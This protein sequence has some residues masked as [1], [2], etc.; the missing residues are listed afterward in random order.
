MSNSQL[1][2]VHVVITLDAGGLERVVIDLVRE[3]RGIGQKASILCIEMPGILAPQAEAIGAAVLCANKGP[4]LRCAAVGRIRSILSQIRPDVVHTHQIEALFYLLPISRRWTPILVHTEH[5]NQFRRFRSIREKL[6]YL[7]MLATAGP[8]ADRI[9]GVSED[10]TQS[11]VSAH[12]VPPRK[13]FTVP[14]GINLARFLTAHGDP[15]LRRS[16]GIPPDGFVFGSI[17]RLTEMKRPD[18]LVTAFDELSAEIPMSHLLIVGDGPMMPDL[19]RQAAASKAVDRIHFAGFQPNPEL[20][21]GL[22]DVFVLTSRMEGMPLAVLE[23]AASGTPVIASRVGGVEEVSNSGR[24][25]LLYD[26]NDMDALLA[27]LR[28]LAS[29]CEFRQQLA[30]SGRDHIRTAYSSERMA[31]DYQAHYEELNLGSGPKNLNRLEVNDATTVHSICA[32]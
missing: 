13:L 29:D 25:V 9:F 17:G 21:L 19:R 28:R 10:A 22:L 5:N 27:G 12:V 30:K 6:R 31:R 14:N 4:G 23:A 1:S 3:A 15:A 8:R 11:V 24:S 32:H 16:L 7:F 26:F 20:Y 18:I 2:I